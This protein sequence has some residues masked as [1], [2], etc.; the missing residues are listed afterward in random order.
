MSFEEVLNVAKAIYEKYESVKELRTECRKVRN[1]SAAVTDVV[2]RLQTQTL[3]LPNLPIG[4]PLHMLNDALREALEVLDICST[5]P[6]RVKLYSATYIGK[7]RAV[8]TKAME[9]LNVLAGAHTSIS[10]DIKQKVHDV[11]EDVDELLNRLDRFKDDI[12]DQIR[13][14]VQEAMS[15]QG[16]VSQQLID[17]LKSGGLV[18]DRDDALRQLAELQREADDVRREKTFVDDQLMTMV[19]QLSLTTSASTSS[20][21]TMPSNAPPSA[22]ICPISLAVMEDPV[23]VNETGISYDRAPLEQWLQ[24]NPNHDPKTNQIFTSRLHYQTNYALRDLIADW[25]TTT[26][27]PSTS[28]EEEGKMFGALSDRRKSK[29][30]TVEAAAENATKEKAAAA[31]AS[32]PSVSSAE[33]DAFMKKV[34]SSLNQVKTAT[35]LNWSN[36]SL[37]ASDAKVIAQLVSS[38]MVPNLRTLK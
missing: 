20:T 5:K 30:A 34:G 27:T 22:F 25:R 28:E 36:K 32:I 33:I 37:T 29:A 38:G 9:A 16:L 12:G 24:T 10:L 4:R 35:E 31:K 14:S 19:C 3:T 6:M 11:G 17:E 1:L 23:Q 13:A 18:K 7:L 26:N 2:E 8:I 21:S 15:Q